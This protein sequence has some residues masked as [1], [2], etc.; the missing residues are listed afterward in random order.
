[1]NFVIGNIYIIYSSWITPPHDKICVCICGQRHWF[2]WVNTNA[3]FHNIGQIPLVARCHGAIP[4]DFVPDLSGVKTASPFGVARR[5]R[6]RPYERRT[7]QAH[8]RCAFGSNRAI[9]RGAQN[10]CAYRPISAPDLRK[11]GGGAAP[12]RCHSSRWIVAALTIHQ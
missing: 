1:M 8:Y 12:R 2:F 4:H 10:L 7:A 11:R 6:S 3:A 9:A 5:E